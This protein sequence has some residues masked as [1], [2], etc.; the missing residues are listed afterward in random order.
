MQTRTE[1]DRAADTANAASE[2]RAPEINDITGVPA[3]TNGWTNDELDRI[4]RAEA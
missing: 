1:G 2:S 4:D 3:Q